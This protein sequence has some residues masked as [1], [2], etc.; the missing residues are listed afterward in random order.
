MGQPVKGFK[1]SSNDHRNNIEL[2]E[3]KDDNDFMVRLKLKQPN[4]QL[5]LIMGSQDKLP[6]DICQLIMAN[7]KPSELSSSDKFMMPVVE[8][9]I[10]RNYTELVGAAVK[11]GKLSGYYIAVMLEKIK[12]KIDEVG[13]KVENEAVMVLKRCAMPAKDKHKNLIFNKPFW[14]VMKQK[15]GHPYFI[16]QI[17][18]TSFMH[19]Q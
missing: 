1:A 4:E 19:K 17:N 10:E 7:K 12:F 8:L 6:Q 13:A 3:Y 5:Y 2:M 14:V 9:D 11:T 15:D 16:C 18:N